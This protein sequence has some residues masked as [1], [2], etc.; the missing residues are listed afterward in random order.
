MRG[1]LPMVITIND[2]FEIVAVQYTKR[3]AGVE[4][5]EV[6]A[7]GIRKQSRKIAEQILEIWI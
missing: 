4:M 3:L 7:K 6:L 1:Y 5:A 2:N